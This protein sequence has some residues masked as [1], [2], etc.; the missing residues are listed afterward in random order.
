MISISTTTFFET[1][2][3]NQRTFSLKDITMHEHNNI[4]AFKLTV[5]DLDM[6]MGLL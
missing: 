5:E 3:K 2:K 6:V 4:N 1:K